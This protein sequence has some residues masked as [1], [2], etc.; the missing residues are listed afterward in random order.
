MILLIIAKTLK[1]HRYQSHGIKNYFH[2]KFN[3][4]SIQGYR[5]ILAN[6]SITTNSLH[7]HIFD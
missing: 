2:A 3:L 6:S 5:V 4:Q 7:L 1:L